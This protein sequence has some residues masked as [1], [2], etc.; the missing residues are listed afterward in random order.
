MLYRRAIETFLNIMT[1]INKLNIF[2][3]IANKVLYDKTKS[4]FISIATIMFAT[5]ITFIGIW[6]SEWIGPNWDLRKIIEKHP[7][8]VIGL[9][10]SGSGWFITVLF[11]FLRNGTKK[12]ELKVNETIKQNDDMIKEIKLL[13]KDVSITKKQVKKIKEKQ[14]G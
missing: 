10:I 14:N 13:R 8:R 2:K 1:K 3:R 6:V 5:L 4:V 7:E 9:V 11:S 12:R